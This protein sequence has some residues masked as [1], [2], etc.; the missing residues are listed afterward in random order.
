MSKEKR[1][2]QSA[3]EAAKKTLEKEQEK[4]LYQ[5]RVNRNR[6]K[7]LADQM[8]KVHDEQFELKRQIVELADLRRA[9]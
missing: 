1:L 8:K 9:L 5:M 4:L 7:T 2:K 6:L 3:I